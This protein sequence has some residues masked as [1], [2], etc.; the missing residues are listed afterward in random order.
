MTPIAPEIALA[1]LLVMLPE[2]RYRLENEKT[3][4]DGV[5]E[6]LTAID[7]PFERE[8]SVG[9]DRFDF[10]CAGSI[11]IEVKVAGSLP[12]ALRQADRYCAHE[13]VSA[14][15]IANS[16]FGFRRGAVSQVDQLRGKPVHAVHLP[17][18][19]F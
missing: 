16:R 13:F 15:V 10:L 5:A 19:W 9:A 3:V 14:V 2:H 12:E 18:R 6:V 11:V 4:Q 7:V 17:G 8:Y 1:R